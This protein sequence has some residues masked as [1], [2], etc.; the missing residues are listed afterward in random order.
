MTAVM[1]D[2]ACAA[3]P[4]DTMIRRAYEVTRYDPTIETIRPPIKRRA[5][6]ITKRTKPTAREDRVIAPPWFDDVVER[7]GQYLSYG[8]NWNGYGE[9]AIT[10]QAVARTVR[11]LMEVAMDGPEPA[12]VPMSDGGIQIEWHYGGTEIEIEVPSD[13]RESS[14]YVTLP[15]GTVLE[16]P[17]KS[18]GDPIWSELRTRI[19]AL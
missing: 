18:P 14:A 6:R 9:N 12:V 4:G 15:D 13:D 7:L 8:E 19:A 17:R 16:R 5:Q 1:R 3:R 2:Y 10:G 11:L